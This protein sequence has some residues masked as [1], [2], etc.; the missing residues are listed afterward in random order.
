M[1]IRLKLVL[2]LVL[3][4]LIIVALATRALLQVNVV[5][6]RFQSINNNLVPALSMAINADRDLHQA[7]VAEREYNHLQSR[8]T[9]SSSQEPTLSAI[10]Q[11]RIENYEQALNRGLKAISLLQ[12]YLP[13]GVDAEFRRT[14]TAWWAASEE[15]INNI[16]YVPNDGLFDAP[17]SILDNLG[18]VAT[19]A[20]KN[21]TG[22]TYNSLH[23]NAMVQLG[24][25]LAAVLICIG[26]VLVGPSLILTPI[27]Q[28]RDQMQKMGAGDLTSRLQLNSQDELGEI[29]DYFNGAI[30]KLQTAIQRISN[31]E[32]RLASSSQQVH[33]TAGSNSQ[34]VQSQQA[35]IDQ[36]VGLL[37]HL[38]AD[39]DQIASSAS[40]TSASAEEALGAVSNGVRMSQGASNDTQRLSQSLNISS[41][42]VS[43]LAGEAENIAAVL[44]VIRGIAEQTNLLALNAAIEAARAGE[45]GRGFAV[46][47]DEVRALA[48]KTQQSTQDIQNRI[49]N[50]HAGVGQ[51]VSAMQEGES[52]LK[53]TLENVLEAAAAFESI[54]SAIHSISQRTAS[55]A[56]ATKG[57]ANEASQISGHI[58]AVAS[59]ASQVTKESQQLS[60]LS[61]ELSGVS[62]ELAGAVH[63]FRL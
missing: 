12:P 21:Y 6:E 61:N 1:T 62:S 5:D 35:N 33:N 30:T 49:E 31:L 11:I 28:L 45:Q 34:L 52:V 56:T 54:E 60:Q 26:V 39:V 63:H 3:V 15:S 51:A 2:P 44:D 23:S 55:I 17:R 58:N 25:S 41:D 50:L 20:A 40:D 38:Q 14:M 4:A 16:N 57:Q 32:S 19:N 46:V 10:N 59:S 8:K 53:T 22:T 27:K 48:S 24:L 47:A 37:N 43:R 42:A 18:E 7:L 9:F 36:M 13:A 29:A